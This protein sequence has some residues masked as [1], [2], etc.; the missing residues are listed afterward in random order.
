M[1]KKTKEPSPYVVEKFTL[2]PLSEVTAGVF[3]YQ[4]HI[5]ARCEQA[6]MSHIKQGT[7][8]SHVTSSE[9]GM[10]LRRRTNGLLRWSTQN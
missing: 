10:H 3:P 1:L 6:F 7:E 4:R 2:P 5:I 9:R 8:K